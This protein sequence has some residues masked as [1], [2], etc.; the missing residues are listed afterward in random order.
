ME[1]HSVYFALHKVCKLDIMMFYLDWW[2][3]K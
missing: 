3:N 1:F 2:R